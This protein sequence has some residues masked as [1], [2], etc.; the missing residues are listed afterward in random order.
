VKKTYLGKFTKKIC[1]TAQNKKV[2]YVKRRWGQF[3]PP[4]PG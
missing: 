2:M 1:S 3:Y 4:S